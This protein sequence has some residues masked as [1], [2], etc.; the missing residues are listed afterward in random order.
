MVFDAAVGRGILE[1]DSAEIL[2]FEVDRVDRSDLEFDPERVR[3]GLQHPERLRM[4]V[5]CGK[6][7]ALATPRDRNAHPERLGGGRRF[8]EKGRV[9]ER[10]TREVRDQRLEVQQSFEPTLRNFGLIGGVLGVPT[11]ILEDVALDYRRNDR[12][13]VTHSDARSDHAVL[14]RDLPEFFDQF[15]LAGRRAF[16]AGQFQRFAETDRR[17][18]GVVG[19][20]VE[21]RVAEVLEHLGDLAVTRTD[22]TVLEDVARFEQRSR[23]F[24][25]ESRVVVCVSSVVHRIFHLEPNAS[26]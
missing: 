21:A 3:A 13:G 14:G 15:E 19:E 26:E 17:G 7:T 23:R 9:G 22:V 8:V 2:G 18:H 25:W 5:R 11:R 24:S 16:E 12:V 1:Q 4:A 6:E 10:Q 20:F